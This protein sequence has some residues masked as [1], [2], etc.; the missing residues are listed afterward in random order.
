MTMSAKE[1]VLKI[2]KE[3]SG[4]IYVVGGYLQAIEEGVR[5]DRAIPT[6]FIKILEEHGEQDVSEMVA[7]CGRLMAEIK[8]KPEMVG[9]ALAANFCREGSEILMPAIRPLIE[10]AR[11]IAAARKQ[12]KSQDATK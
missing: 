4:W 6:E 12:A 9:L 2:I 5:F 10:K 3:F 7:D 8:E 1:S 11:A